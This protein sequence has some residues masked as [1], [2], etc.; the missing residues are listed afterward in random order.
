ML[1][2]GKEIAM[3]NR[4]IASVAGAVCLAAAAPALADY[5]QQ[6][7]R[8]IVPFSPGG[9]IDVASRMLA[10]QLAADL[11]QP[12]VVENR[13]GAGGS[14]GAQAVARASP[15]GYTVLSGSNGMLAVNPAVNPSLPYDPVKSFAPVAFISRVPLALTVH[16]KLPVKDLASLRDYARSSGA[17]ISIGSSGAG[18]AQ[19][20]AI[21]EFGE[22]AGIPYTHV[23]YRGGSAIM[24][25]LMAGTINAALN[26]LPNVLSAHR[27]GQVRVI[28]VAADQRS[29]LLPDVPTL[30]EAGLKGFV[31]YSSNG[32]LVP[33]DTPKAVIQTLN[34]ALAKALQNP[35]IRGKMEGMGVVVATPEEMTA[36]AYGERLAG[37]LRQ[38]KRT[39][40]RHKIRVSQ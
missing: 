26:E 19:H 28:A 29:P 20:L 36:Q 7:V 24:P 3:L 13:P 25:D 18:G 5:P 17:P 21:V 16:G 35:D 33:I 39:A 8:V 32:W 6:P 9:N 30:E 22:Q 31:A 11:G 15:D 2:K 1:K 37:E 23:P 10:T 12:F 27:E 14:I 4:F 34:D 38:A 40:D